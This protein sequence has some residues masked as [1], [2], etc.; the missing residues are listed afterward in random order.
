MGYVPISYK[1]LP[2]PTKK[3]FELNTGLYLSK[4]ENYKSPWYL[5]IFKKRGK[6]ALH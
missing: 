5:I 6:N 4:L 1:D 3:E 2:L